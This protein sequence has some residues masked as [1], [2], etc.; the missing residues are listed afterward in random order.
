MMASSSTLL[1]SLK[2]NKIIH[3]PAA[4]LI[5]IYLNSH[6]ASVQYNVQADVYDL[7]HTSIPDEYQNQGLGKILAEVDIN[8]VL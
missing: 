5:S 8:F 1:N 3:D 4:Q 7:V 6:S 2:A